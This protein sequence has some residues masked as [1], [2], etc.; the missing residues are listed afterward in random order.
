M[1]D[2]GKISNIL[3]I[4]C[5]GETGKIYLLQ[6]KYVDELVQRFSMRNAKI[7]STPIES[8]LKI[9]KQ[10]YPQTKDEKC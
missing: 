4:Q 2:L 10:I 8:N 6:Q 7:V 3:E 9:S 5:E 1:T